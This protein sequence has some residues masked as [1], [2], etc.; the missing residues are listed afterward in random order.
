ML[1]NYLKSFLRNFT[2]HRLFSA[3]N[4]LGLAS[5]LACCVLI[6]VFVAYERTFDHQYERAD[7][8]YRV[9]RDFFPGGDSQLNLRLATMPPAAAEL[10]RQDYP[11]IEQ[12][13]RMYPGN[14]LIERDNVVSYEQDYWVD[15]TFFEL[16]DLEW[17]QGDPA[18][19]LAAPFSVV[20]TESVARKYF[21]DDDPMGQTLAIG[22]YG[23]SKVTGVI[24][25][26]PDNTHFEF[27]LLGSM[28]TLQSIFDSNFFTRWGN[29]TFYTYL[30]LKP[31]AAD[32]IQQQSATFFEKYVGDGSSASTGFSLM[33]L[34]DIHL[35]SDRVYEMKAPGSL[36]QVYTFTAMA[37]FILLIG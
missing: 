28:S 30:L 24:G 8:I 21:G 6:G 11:Q 10:L 26:L 14:F 37:A 20:V 31:D 4:I 16:F 23:P 12:S 35:H 13:A 17:L 36:S 33:P 9:S 19:A 5:G 25:D 22:G 32:V 7:R 15:P 1:K 3:I 18:T 27:T 29:N 2:G 34:V